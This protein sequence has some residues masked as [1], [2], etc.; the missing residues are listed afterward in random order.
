MAHPARPIMSTV[1]AAPETAGSSKAMAAAVRLE[2]WRV[3]VVMFAICAQRRRREKSVDR[4]FVGGGESPDGRATR[5][6]EIDITGE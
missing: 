3:T 4:A 5:F 1:F 2:H 6:V